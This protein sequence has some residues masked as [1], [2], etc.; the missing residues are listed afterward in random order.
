LGIT[1]ANVAI[2]RAALKEVAANSDQATDKGSNGFGRVYEL[3]FQL[4]TQDGT[5]TILSGWI[6]REGEGFP[7]LTTCFILTA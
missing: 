1:L 4:K 3:R 7:R 6:I 2:L 5:A